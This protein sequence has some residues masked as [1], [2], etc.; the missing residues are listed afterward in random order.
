MRVGCS[1]SDISGHILIRSKDTDVWLIALLHCSTVS[2]SLLFSSL[3]LVCYSPPSTSFFPSEN[4][5]I[6]APVLV[7]INEEHVLH[8][9]SVVN[10]VQ[11]RLRSLQ[12]LDRSTADPCLSFV[13]LFLMT[14]LPSPSPLTS[15]CMHTQNSLILHR[16]PPS[17]PF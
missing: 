4:K 1:R 8:I 7:N 3:L 2:V 17:F 15:T 10:T 16:L 11:Q 5:R 12:Y 6:T 14:G 9:D 13:L